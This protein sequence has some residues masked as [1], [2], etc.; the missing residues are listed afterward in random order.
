MN[1]SVIEEEF[2]L[3]QKIQDSHQSTVTLNLLS[4]LVKMQ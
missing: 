4:Q 1:R 2:I 3:A